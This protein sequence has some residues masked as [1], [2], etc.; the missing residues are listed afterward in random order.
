MSSHR[1]I[2]LTLEYDGTAYHGWQIQPG[3]PTVQGSIEEVLRHITR[4]DIRVI[5]AGR[6]DAGVHARGQVAHF[7]TISRLSIQTFQRALNALLPPDIAVL[8]TIEV[9]PIFHARYDAIRRTY[10]Y[11][12]LNR[13]IRSVFQRHCVL[14][15]PANLHVERMNQMCTI[16]MGTHDF[17]SFQKKG[18]DR[19]NPVCTTY[20]VRWWRESDTVYFRITA[21]SFLR[22]MVRAIVGSCLRWQ[23]DENA[24]EWMRS[25]LAA[26]DRASAGPSA[27]ACG[28][29]LIKVQ[30]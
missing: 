8:E 15:R 6:T 1:N 17:S 12:I 27:P 24:E 5:G 4:E 20:E 11:T 26:R 7:H 14:H 22:G 30:Y 28:L 13:S 16:L 9:D 23:H 2:K 10:C 19:Q 21:D 3:L 29:C 25:I 18:S